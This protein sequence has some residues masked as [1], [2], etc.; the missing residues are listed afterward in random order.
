MASREKKNRKERK[1]RLGAIVG[2]QGGEVR[3]GTCKKCLFTD[4]LFIYIVISF[5]TILI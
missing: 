3:S 4:L 1:G 5:I 2:R